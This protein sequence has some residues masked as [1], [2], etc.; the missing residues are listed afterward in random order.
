M[1]ADTQKVLRRFLRKHGSKA[2]AAFHI[3]M[4][5]LSAAGSGGGIFSPVPVEVICPF[6]HFS[7]LILTLLQSLCKQ[8]Q[9]QVFKSD[10][11]EICDAVS[12]VNA[13][14][15]EPRNCCQD[16]NWG[17]PRGRSG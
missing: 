16:F 1:R 14:D 13:S 7:S 4:L 3:K 5:Q 9:R 12:G 15:S 10:E 11:P 17:G 2:A 6:M 8:P